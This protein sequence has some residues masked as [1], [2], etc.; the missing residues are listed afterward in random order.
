MW[1]ID[2][3]R[4]REI[5]TPHLDIHQLMW[6][7][8]FERREHQHRNMYINVVSLAPDQLDPSVRAS[9]EGHMARNLADDVHHQMGVF[10]LAPPPFTH[11]GDGL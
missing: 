6:L 5:F 4:T 11:F 7:Q 3:W 10:V 8:S 2:S 9:R 1:S